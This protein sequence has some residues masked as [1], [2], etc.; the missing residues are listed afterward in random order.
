MI[1]DQYMDNWVAVERLVKEWKKYE[2][3]VIAVDFDNT[4]YDFHNE[5]YKYEYVPELIRQCKEFGAYIVIWTASTEERYRFMRLYLDENNI[6]FDTINENP[7]GVDLPE[8]RKL[9]YNILLD[10]RAGLDSAVSIL[11][12]ALKTMKGGN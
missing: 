8:G 9:Y 7:L 4:L 3:I 6:P 11:E 5:G 10:D 12:E 1:N 2:K